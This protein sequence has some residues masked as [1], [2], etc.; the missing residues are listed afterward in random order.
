MSQA[1]GGADPAASVAA[2]HGVD[3]VVVVFKT[4]FDI[5]Y[6]DMAANVVHQYRTSMIDQA[7][8]VVDAS[9]D[10]PPDRQFVWTIPGWPLAK[11]LEEWPGQTAHR[12]SRVE[13]AFRQGRF[14]VHALPFTTH[15][16][17][18]ELEDLVWG[19]GY[20]SGLSRRFGMPLPRDAKMTDVPCHSWAIVTLLKRAGVDFL[21]L[22]CNAGSSS[23]RVPRLFWW[24]GPDGSR[25]LTMYSEAGYGTDLVPPADWPFRTWLAL[26]HTGDNHG[27][28]TPEEVRQ[29]FERAKSQLPQVRIRIGR[30]ADFAAAI[31]REDAKI[32]VVRGDMP[33]TWIHGPM[34]DPTGASKVRRIRPSITAA[35]ALDTLLRVWKVESYDARMALAVA[36]QNSLLYGEHTWGGALSWITSLA[37]DKISFPYGEAFRRDLARGR[38]DRLQSSWDEHTAYAE[39]AHAQ[40][41]LVLESHLRALAQAI[42][43]QG[44]RIVVFNPL[45]WKRDGVVSAVWKHGTVEAVAPADGGPAV[46]CTLEG[47][48]LRFLARDVPALGYRTYVPAKA[49]TVPPLEVDAQ[50]ATIQTPHFQATLDPV[51]GCVRSLVDKKTGRELVD[52]SG[53]YGFGQYLYERFDA[54]QVQAYVRDY[55]KIKADWA[56]NEIGKPPMPPASQS[57]Y[58]AVSPQ[59]CSLH[60]ENRPYEVVAVMHAPASAQLP[61]A[62]TTRLVLYRD[63]PYADLEVTV[64]D[65]PKDSWPE[66]CWI[67]FPLQVEQP[68][69]RLGRLGSIVDPARQLVPG[70]NHD[71]LWLNTGLSVTDPKGH[72][73]GLCPLDHPLVSLERPGCFRYTPEFVPTKPAVFVN[74]FNN[75]WT[76]NFR[77]WNGG[78]WT[79]RVRLWAVQGDGPATAIIVPSA[80]ARSPLLAC[81]GDGPAGPLPKTR[82]GLELSLP[83]V[84][85]GAFGP[86]PDG[87]GL[88]LR[89]W[90][91]SGSSGPCEVRLPEGMQL[92]EV[93]PVNL[94]G[95]PCGPPTAVKDRSFRFRLER[96]APASFVLPVPDAPQQAQSAR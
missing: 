80:E 20:S 84:L 26:I 30:L 17:T 14:A 46:P 74:F 16:E 85:L 12:K 13:Q 96:F 63:L 93:V 29:L 11:I 9:R 82:T 27:P 69:F 91:A 35:Q 78:T 1:V 21:H 41:T 15:T 37:P 56:I 47:Q 54:D 60:F 67:C 75:H 45:P 7:L 33:D 59:N 70:S 28:P 19:L 58:R 65:K 61:D 88:V 90:E 8:K 89:L 5:G 4:H 39:I 57:P 53:P 44:P 87:P 31:L 64:H 24:E 92:T 10:L 18:L 32:P 49:S 48:N 25:L 86:N 36:R 22:G 38:F 83:G 77:M 34:C 52:S 3:E 73:V 2:R 94:R 62:V 79:S 95:E 72:G 55:V 43:I 76:T 6:T 66:A 40:T 50:T 42:G 51:R 23:P 68:R 81:A 71:L